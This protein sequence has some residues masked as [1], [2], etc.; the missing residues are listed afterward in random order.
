MTTPITTSST[1]S[2]M[3]NNIMAAVSK[4]RPPMLAMGRFAQWRSRF[5]RYIDTK[6]NGD[7]LRKCI[8][9]GPYNPTTVVV[10]AVEATDDSLAIPQHTTIET[11]L[12]MSEEN[13]AHFHAE[14]EAIF[15]LLTGELLNIQDVKTN[16]FWKFG[17]FTSRDEESME[18]YY[19][20][21]YKM[22]KEMIRNNF[23]VATMQYKKEFNEIEPERIAKSA[24]PLAFVA[25]AQQYLDNYYQAPKPQRSY[26]PAPKPSF[27]TRSIAPTRHKGKEIAK[28]I[29]LPSE[30][31]SDEDIDPEQ[32]QKDKEMQ[33]K[34]ALIAKDQKLAT[35][36]PLREFEFSQLQERILDV[37]PPPPAHYP[38]SSYK[39]SEQPYSPSATRPTDYPS[40][41]QYKP[42][43]GNG[44][45][46]APVPES[47][48]IA[49]Q[50]YQ[51]DI[52]MNGTIR[53]S[54]VEMNGTIRVYS[55]VLCRVDARASICEEMWEDSKTNKKWVTMTRYFLP[56]DL[57]KRVCHPCAPESNEEG[58]IV[59]YCNW[60][61][62]IWFFS[63]PKTGQTGKVLE[64]VR[65]G[66]GQIETKCYSSDRWQWSLSDDGEFS[67]SS[68]RCLI[69]DKSL[70]S[71]GLKT[72]WCKGVPIKVNILSWRIKHDLLP[73][74]FN[75]SRRGMDLDTISCPC[76]N[77]APE[78]TNHLLFCCSL[79][80]DLYKLIAS[81]W[82]IDFMEISSYE[83]WWDWFS[84]LR[85]QVYE[86]NYQLTLLA[87]SIHSP[88][89]VLPPKKFSEERAM[90]SR[91]Q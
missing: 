19:S 2:Q 66:M 50:S 48:S 21:F 30:S 44:S 28:P 18:S 78:T 11:I 39:G 42:S 76:C 61:V 85:L 89:E 80:K 16:L 13:K 8:L 82:D 57:P 37:A 87:G 14:K 63:F 59:D 71:V 52:E 22:M 17:K 73:T 35:R 3:Y 60:L 12:N 68:I 32:A 90:Q 69:D 25:A 15:L 65:N 55:A 29:T 70:D 23:Q 1:D 88:C 72:R 83:S 47:A 41:G 81:W 51:Y 75:I 77:L 49:S 9:E 27:S 64:L 46:P 62:E 6:T 54:I 58:F 79:A 24:N 56:D 38:S 43:A 40:T 7:T 53:F 67:V 33:K 26:A 84:S 86:S 20:Q 5:L 4:D 36:V 34:L 74:R 45:A 91:A 31:G 10:S